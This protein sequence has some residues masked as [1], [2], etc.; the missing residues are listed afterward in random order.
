MKPLAFLRRHRWTL[1]A[2][3]LIYLGIVLWLQLAAQ[4]A[5]DAPF[6]Y[7]VY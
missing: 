5:S 6:V 4:D 1:L 7:Q 2:V 3:L